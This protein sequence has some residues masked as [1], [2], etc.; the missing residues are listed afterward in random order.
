MLSLLQTSLFAQ[1]RVSA[2]ISGENRNEFI[3]TFLFFDSISFLTEN[4]TGN[5]VHTG[6]TIL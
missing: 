4:L 1:V 3:H 2:D 6:V 5:I